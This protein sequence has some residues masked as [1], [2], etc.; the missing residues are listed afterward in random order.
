[1][2]PLQKNMCIDNL[3]NR[4]HKVYVLWNKEQVNTFYQNGRW[5][6]WRLTSNHIAIKKYAIDKVI[7]N[8]KYGLFFLDMGL[9]KNSINTYSI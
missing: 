5:N 8:E 2:H 7:D 4:D 6:I 9:G 3:K 1:M